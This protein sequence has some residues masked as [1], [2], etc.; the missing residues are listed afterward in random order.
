MDVELHERFGE[1]LS[2]LTDCGDFH[3]NND[4]PFKNFANRILNNCDM[5]K[6]QHEKFKNGLVSLL[7][8]IDSF[9]LNDFL[10]YQS[11]MTHLSRTQCLE[12][13]L[14]LRNSVANQIMVNASI[15]CFLKK[16]LDA[17]ADII[18]STTNPSSKECLPW[19][20]Y[21]LLVDTQDSRANDSFKFFIDTILKGIPPRILDL[22]AN[23]CLN[24]IGNICTFV[25]AIYHLKME[26]II[27][28]VIK[29]QL[30]TLVSLTLIPTKETAALD[31]GW[32][33]AFLHISNMQLCKDNQYVLLA[34]KALSV[35]PKTQMSLMACDVLLEEMKLLKCPILW[36]Y[37]FLILEQ[38]WIK[39]R[40]LEQ[41]CNF[42]IKEDTQD[43]NLLTAYCK[44]LGYLTCIES[45]KCQIELSV[46]RCDALFD[47]HLNCE[48]KS[49]NE[50]SRTDSTNLITLCE[51]LQN[52]QHID[53]INPASFYDSLN[54]VLKHNQLLCSFGV[55]FVKS[56]CEEL[57]KINC[58]DA[59]KFLK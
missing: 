27:P 55:P 22:D 2:F 6:I 43:P 21:I 3:S 41:I 36:T 11:F 4:V 24:F 51:Y 17:T 47:F 38:S 40:S 54:K 52:H 18:M 16:A 28:D 29:N 15:S 5:S 58:S 31:P 32:N 37:S 20:L 57:F 50:F 14:H 44:T 26:H 42:I 7:K 45:Q 8:M 19:Y 23:T 49:T 48:C 10:A 33:A 53:R 34:T 46:A 39:H 35:L 59:S 1:I 12:L 13:A 25:T 30:T 56:V 9:S